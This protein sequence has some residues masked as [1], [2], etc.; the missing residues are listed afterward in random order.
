MHYDNI[1]D[2]TQREFDYVVIGGGSAGAA[3][4]ARLSEDGDALAVLDEQHGEGQGNH[5]FKLGSPCECRG[6][7]DRGGQERSAGWEVELPAGRHG[8][9]ACHQG[10]QDRR[11]V[12][13]KPG[14][15]G[16]DQECGH[17]RCSHGRI[18]LGGRN[19]VCAELQEH[20]GHHGH[21]ERHRHQRH[22][23]A[24]HAGGAQGEDQHAGG[25]EGPDDFGEG[26]VLKR[27]SQE[28][29]AGDGPGETQG[30]PVNEGHQQRGRP[31]GK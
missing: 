26:Q 2:A 14:N 17:H 28:H 12:P 29:R 20:R 8:D 1:D 23:S 6:G 13:A 15:C 9:A 7:E 3:V 27:R 10:A 24:H 21:H 16:E 4:A 19:D 30:L 31:A 22:G 5:Q 11:Q 18:V 25:E